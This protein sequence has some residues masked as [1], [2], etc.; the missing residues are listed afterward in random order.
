VRIQ[1]PCSRRIHSL[2][3]HTGN[4]PSALILSYVLH[5]NIPYYI[6]GHQDTVLDQ[7]L[8]QTPNLLHVKPDTYCH[9][10]S[11]LRYSSQALPINVLLDTLLRPSGD[12]DLES[13]T[14]IQWRHEPAKAV[15]HIVIGNAP[16]AGGQWAD[17][18]IS[19]S[20]DIGSLSYAEQLSLPGYSLA[21]HW[22]VTRKTALPELL[23]PTRTDISDYYA[24]YPKAV[25]IADAIKTSATVSDIVRTP[26]GT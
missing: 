26:Q 23:R 9:L 5:G 6:G 20:W 7:K 24:A 25:G 13:E 3:I 17:N 15:N 2:T 8:R 19:A 4:G 14:C 18:L 21:D 1:F 10:Q 12:T 16:R 22:R 11:S